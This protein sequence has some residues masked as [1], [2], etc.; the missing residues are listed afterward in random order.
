MKNCALFPA[1][2]AIRPNRHALR[3]PLTSWGKWGPRNVDARHVTN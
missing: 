2:L 3:Q 1:G